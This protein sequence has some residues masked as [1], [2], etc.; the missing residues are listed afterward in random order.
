MRSPRIIVLQTKPITH[1]LLI[2]TACK[3]RSFFDST[4][5]VLAITR[6][7]HRLLKIVHAFYLAGQKKL[8][9]WANC[10]P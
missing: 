1:I 4:L 10:V 3:L 9:K 8:F 7:L 2:L 5:F 6:E